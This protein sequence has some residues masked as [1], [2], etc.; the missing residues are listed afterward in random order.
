M[1]PAGRGFSRMYP[2]RNVLFVCHANTSRSVMAEHLLVRLLSDHA[3]PPD[4]VAVTSGGIAPYARDGS[5]VSLDTRLVL[6]DVDIHLEPDAVARDLK[7]GHRHLLEQADL[8]LTMTAEQVAM[9]L[10][11]LADREVP[12]VTLRDFAGLGGDIADPAGQDENVFVLTRN[13]VAHALEHA[14][15]KLVPGAPGL[16]TASCPECA[17]ERNAT[18]LKD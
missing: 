16:D 1:I 5:L 12:V 3:V 17:K 18:A 2:Y 15:P 10:A 11:Q 14:L 4:A 8:I 7:R 13:R 9:V 6:R